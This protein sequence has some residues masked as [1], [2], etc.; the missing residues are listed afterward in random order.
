MAKNVYYIKNLRTSKFYGIYGFLG[1]VFIT[2]NLISWFKST[3]LYCTELENMGV[4]ALVK[5]IGNIR[6]LVKRI[7]AGIKVNIP[8]LTKLAKLIA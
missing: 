7:S 5:T 8:L 6:D 4:R 1:L 2:H 3:V